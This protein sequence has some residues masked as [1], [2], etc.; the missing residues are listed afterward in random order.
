MLAIVRT[1]AEVR[2]T[3]VYGSAKHP[4]LK[5]RSSFWCAW[6]PAIRMLGNTRLLSMAIMLKARTASG[7]Q[8]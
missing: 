7:G 5:H 4:T 8:I 1:R 2:G 6:L 3:T